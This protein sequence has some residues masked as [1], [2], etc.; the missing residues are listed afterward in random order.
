MARKAVELS[1]YVV[2]DVTVYREERGLPARSKGLPDLL[3]HRRS[4]RDVPGVVEDRV[5]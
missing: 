2:G 5:A 3:D 1:D 4:V